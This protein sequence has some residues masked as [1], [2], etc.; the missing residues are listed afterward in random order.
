MKNLSKKPAIQHAYDFVKDSLDKRVWK[1]GECL[2]SIRRLSAMASVSKAS[3]LK[4]IA[5]LADQG[6]VSATQR[7]RIKAGNTLAAITPVNDSRLLLSQQVRAVFE[8]ELLSGSF[9][10]Q[11]V[12]PPLKELQ[13][14]YG[15]SF[16]TMKR[17]LQSMVADRVIEPHGKGYKIPSLAIRSF[18]PRIVFITMQ[19]HL[20]QY[21]A[22]NQEHNRIANAFENECRRLGMA[23]EIIEIDFYDAGKT[24]LAISKLVD[25]DSIS[26]F[27]FDVWWY[28]NEQQQNS[29]LDILRRLGSFCKPVT[30]LDEL[31]NFQLPTL[32]TSNPLIQVF[33]IEAKMA[34]IRMARF[35][36]EMGHRACV[37]ISPF[38]SA[39]WSRDRYSG[40]MEQFYQVGYENNVHSIVENTA[41]SFMYML[42]MSGLENAEIHRLFVIGRTPAQQ[43]DIEATWAAYR[44]S[45]QPQ[46]LDK[47]D[48]RTTLRRSLAPL[49]V[50]MRGGFSDDLLEKT[51]S[52]VIDTSAE[53]L[54]RLSFKPFFESALQYSDTT[55]WICSNDFT[56]FSAISFLHARGLQPGKDISVVGFDNAPSKAL[57]RQLTTFDFNAMGFVKQIL[58]FILRPTKPRGQYRHS[59][60]EVEGLIIERGTTGHKR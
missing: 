32:Y 7:Y 2:P 50:L 18:H 25:N 1:E 48:D 5:L 14:R 15:V 21:S 26:G 8:R 59:T 60:I 35:L 54:T 28:T 3:M 39:M 49:L 33:R 9:G 56:A 11:G 46:L 30:L 55:A 45:P 24:R 31:G 47:E 52:T 12:L 29:C 10:Y 41:E 51:L 20:A 16:G 42:T 19:G 44:E 4:A 38:H 13:S 34:G 43:K 58:G 27:I 57:E 22:L 37:Y 17:I 53:I 23:M 6:L 36:L 40:I